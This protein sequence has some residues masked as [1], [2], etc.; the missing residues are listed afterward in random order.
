MIDLGIRVIGRREGSVPRAPI[1]A[2]LE[3]GLLAAAQAVASDARALHLLRR[4]PKRPLP[5]RLAESITAA[6]DPNGLAATV[7]AGGP[8]APYAAVVEFGAAGRPAK[9]FLYPALQMNRRRIL[10]SLLRAGGGR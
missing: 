7:K 10:E 8:R 3:E 2:G 1:E 5:S 4:D 6:R 9:P